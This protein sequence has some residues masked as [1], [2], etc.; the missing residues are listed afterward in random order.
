M[1][2][3]ANDFLIESILKSIYISS[4]TLHPLLVTG[5]CKCRECLKLPVEHEKQK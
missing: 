1:E 3:E 2:K 4:S 5:S